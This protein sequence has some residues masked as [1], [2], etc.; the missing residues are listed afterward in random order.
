MMIFSFTPLLFTLYFYITA[1]YRLRIVQNIARLSSVCTSF[2]FWYTFLCVFPALYL[3]QFWKNK[4][5]KKQNIPAN[6]Y[7]FCMTLRIFQYVYHIFILDNY[8]F[9]KK[10]NSYDSLISRSLNSLLYGSLSIISS[11]SKLVPIYVSIKECSF[12]IN[13]ENLLS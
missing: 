1:R 8:Y 2:D 9:F 3:T 4:Q 5:N 10:A 7:F 13:N 12:S 11:K 6:P